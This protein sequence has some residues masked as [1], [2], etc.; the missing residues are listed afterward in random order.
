LAKN[1]QE[2]WQF[3]PVFD[4][5]GRVVGIASVTQSV[6]YDQDKQAKLQMVFKACVPV[7]RI[8]RLLAGGDS[9]P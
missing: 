3:T 7:H 1:R 4:D 8:R 9:A 6:Y 5:A 2:F